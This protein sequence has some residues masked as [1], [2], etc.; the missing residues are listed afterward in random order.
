[1]S[2]PPDPEALDF[3]RAHLTLRPAPARPDIRLYQAHAGSRL[4]RLDELTI[5]GA[6]NPYWAY[7]WAGGGGLARF[8][9][10]QPETAAGRRVLDLGTG[11]GLV[12]IAAMKAGAREVVAADVDPYALAALSLNAAANKVEV[13][14]VLGDL[15]RGEP[16]EVD[17][18]AIGDLFYDQD[19][20]AQVTAFLDRCLDAGA[21]VLVGD[22]KRAHLPHARLRELAEYA[23]PDFGDGASNAKT[24]SWVFAFEEAAPCSP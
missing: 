17:L 4:S 11:G 22:P 8:L 2:T 3:I 9:L 6:L 13:E 5:S 14:G 15:T 10:D 16:P 23:V 20:A 21:E 1:M 19:T 18:V 12:A 24:M 7:P